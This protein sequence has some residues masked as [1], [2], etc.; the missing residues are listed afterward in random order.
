MI[1]LGWGEA[2]GPCGADKTYGKMFRGLVCNGKAPSN[3]GCYCV[4]PLKRRGLH[5]FALLSWLLG[6]M[7]SYTCVGAFTE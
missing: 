7:Q 1:K 3:I 5:A 2:G 6:M 4:R